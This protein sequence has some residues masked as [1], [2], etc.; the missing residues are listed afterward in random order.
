[1]ISAILFDLVGTLVEESSSDLNTKNGYYEI[2]VKAIHCSLEKDNISV[3]WPLFKKQYEQVR[4]RQKEKSRQTLK[5]YDMCKRVSDTLHFFNYEL[6]STS[7]VIRR[8]VDAYMIPYVNSLRIK[9][10]TYNLLRTLATKY[11]LGLVTNFAYS[12]G[13][14]RV[15][16]RFA[17]RYFF[18]VIVISGEIGWKKPSKRI[19]KIA[20]SQLSFKPE[21]AVL[22]GDNYEADI[23]GAKKAGMRT[24]F[25]CKEPIDGE[26]ADITIE[27]LTELPLA[28]E[29]LLR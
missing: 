5:E 6:P 17:L 25:L 11:N 15:L 10:S 12:P 27:S 13:A 4:M 8:A 1:M 16:E 7:K 18:K 14:Y 22:V 23:V 29:Q 19:F 2:Q 21:E 28:I 3:D 9:Q 20:L 24:V 26:K